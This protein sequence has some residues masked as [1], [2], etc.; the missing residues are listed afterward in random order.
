MRSF[1]FELRSHG[2]LLWLST[3]GFSTF[4][5]S[6]C[7]FY[8]VAVFAGA[9]G[10]S[11]NL[12]QSLALCNRPCTQTSSIRPILLNTESHAFSPSLKIPNSSK[13][14][15]HAT[16]QASEQ[17]RHPHLGDPVCQL[18]CVGHRRR[19]AHEP[20]L[21]GAVDDGLLPDGAPGD[22]A[23]VVHL[24][25]DDGLDVGQPAAEKHSLLGF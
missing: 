8:R 2:F 5:L 4:G 17:G 18:L 21:R 7:K 9:A 3:L 11:P 1:D 13:A 24:V 10:S 19:E 25:Q 12:K 16:C 14:S 15:W 23:Q 6:Q 22:V 20:D